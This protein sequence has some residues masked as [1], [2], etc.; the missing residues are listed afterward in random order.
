MEQGKQSRSRAAGPRSPGQIRRTK[1]PPSKFVVLGEFRK[2]KGHLPSSRSFFGLPRARNVDSIP[3]CF[4]VRAAP[5]ALPKG[6]PPR[7][8]RRKASNSTSDCGLSWRDADS[9]LERLVGSVQRGQRRQQQ[10]GEEGDN[11]V[12]CGSV[13]WWRFSFACGSATV[14]SWCLTDSLVPIIITPHALSQIVGFLRLDQQFIDTAPY[15]SSYI[16]P[17][18]PSRNSNRWKAIKYEVS[19]NGSPAI[20]RTCLLAELLATEARLREC[21]RGGWA[22]LRKQGNA[23]SSPRMAIKNSQESRKNEIPAA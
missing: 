3:N 19:S 4:A 11:G 7:T 1:P 2:A 23:T 22:L 17:R 15:F 12:S 5:S 13:H 18:V 21:L 6:Q 20:I 10:G 16:I 8:H 9:T 14:Q